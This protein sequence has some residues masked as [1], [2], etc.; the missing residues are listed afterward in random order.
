MS[1]G[2]SKIARRY[3]RALLELYPPP[4]FDGVSKALN[5]LARIWSA[6][7][8][9]A[10]V[11]LNPATPKNE[12][13]SVVVD[14]AG[15]VRPDD[16]RFSNYLLIL[17]R[18]KRFASAPDIARQF[19]EYVAQFRKLSKLEVQS[20]VPLASDEMSSITKTIEHELGA[21]VAIDWHAN[22]DILGGLRIRIGDRMLDS[23]IRG[24]L[25]RLRV[26]LSA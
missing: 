26:E 12:R 19:D 23:S 9:V 7:P 5:E 14:L 13:E 16:K 18:N 22:P 20:A 3:A 17:F 15:R 2:S 24:Q 8:S 25:D 11:L 4:E 10:A 6:I 1:R 21:S